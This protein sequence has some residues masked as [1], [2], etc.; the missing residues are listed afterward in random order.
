VL[1]RHWGVKLIQGVGRAGLGAGSILGVLALVAACVGCAAMVLHAVCNR[2]DAYRARLERE[3]TEA[4][5]AC[6][7]ARAHDR[8]VSCPPT[9]HVN[10]EL[11]QAMGVP[12]QSDQ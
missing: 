3:E 1:L 7:M 12:G 2:Y 6:M 5:M 4:W 10:R 11:L 8:T 9:P